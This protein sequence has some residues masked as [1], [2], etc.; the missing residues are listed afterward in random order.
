[1]R[2]GREWGKETVSLP[3]WTRSPQVAHGPQKCRAH[4]PASGYELIPVSPC[5]RSAAQAPLLPQWKIL[6]SCRYFASLWAAFPLIS[7]SSEI[8]SSPSSAA[9]GTIY[10][11]GCSQSE[12]CRQLS[13]ACWV[14]ATWFYSCRQGWGREHLH[15]AATKLSER[16]SLSS[17]PVCPEGTAVVDSA[18]RSFVLLD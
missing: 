5:L 12:G 14:S 17:H 3:A 2:T 16:Q 7:F 15:C 13:G 6:V 18:P 1:M 4:Q 9:D 11:Q 10:F 8:L